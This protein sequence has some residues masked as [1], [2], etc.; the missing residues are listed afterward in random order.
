V[1]AAKSFDPYEII[2]IITPGTVMT[3]LVA[4]EVP[5]F[6]SMLGSKGLSVGDFGLFILVAFVFG[7]LVQAV[8]NMTERAVWPLSGL[9]T[10]LVRLTDQ[11]LLSAAQCR[12]LRMKVA[13]MEGEDAELNSFDKESWRSVT[14]RAFARVRNAGRSGRIDISNRTYGLCRGLVAALALTLGWCVYAHRD[15]TGLLVALALMI[16]AAIWR[17]R[18]AGHHYARALFLE[19]I[20]LDASYAR[21]A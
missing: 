16:A 12:E 14:T 8:G 19:F 6:R 20:D 13:A 15:H 4:T 18:R 5:I 7:H 17:M 10:N 9:P 21:T 11:K 3:L 1:E 2:G